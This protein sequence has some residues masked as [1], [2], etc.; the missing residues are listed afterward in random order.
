MTEQQTSA[1]RSIAK[2]NCFIQFF[3]A[4]D[5]ERPSI[6]SGDEEKSELKADRI[7]LHT[8]FGSV[9]S[10]ID[11]IPEPATDVDR[12]IYLRPAHFGAVSES[13]IYISTA[14]AADSRQALVQ[15]KVD[16]PFS[17]IYRIQ[18]LKREQ[19]RGESV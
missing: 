18:S 9:P 11:E 10:T 3:V 7:R 19:K 14:A 2:P 16:A 17:Y 1:L 8:A 12:R 13:G 5:E 4:A 15:T 6:S